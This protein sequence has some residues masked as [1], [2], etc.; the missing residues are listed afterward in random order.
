MFSLEGIGQDVAQFMKGCD[1]LLSAL[2]HQATFSKSEKVLISHYC[3]EIM[4]Q[5]QSLRDEVEKQ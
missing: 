4:S 2:N 3:R 5:T 1:H